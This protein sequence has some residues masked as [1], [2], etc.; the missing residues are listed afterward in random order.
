[1]HRRAFLTAAAAAPAMTVFGRAVASADPMSWDFALPNGFQP[2][3]I[4]I[5]PGPFAYLASLADG[6]VFRYDLRSGQGTMI[7][8]VV[9]TDDVAW[10]T[11]SCHPELYGLQLRGAEPPTEFV[12]LPL[13][14]DVVMAEGLN[15]NGIARTPDRHARLTTPPSA[16]TTYNVVAVRH[17]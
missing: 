16:D 12:R 1:M 11:D 10:L 14:G 6:C 7:N 3:G 17:R 13:S 2:E 8:D 15:A 5:G 4:T 9:L